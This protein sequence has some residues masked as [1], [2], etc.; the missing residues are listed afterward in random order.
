MTNAGPDPAEMVTLIDTPPLGVTLDEVTSSQGICSGIGPVTCDLGAIEAG[1]SRT[2]TL[3]VIPTVEG[4]LSNSAA[5]LSSTL[6]PNLLDNQALKAVNV[7][8]APG[9]SGGCTVNGT[10]GDDVLRG[11]S[12]RDVICGLGGS[13]TLYGLGGND[14]LKGS[15]G[16]DFLS[17]G[18]G[19]DRLL[20]GAGDDTMKGSGGRDTL[21]GGPGLDRFS[22]GGGRDRCANKDGEPAKGC[23]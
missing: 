9:G 7:L 16:N 4:L 5:V 21:K 6:D 18:A 19:K 15:L 8:A 12:G 17:G 3:G 2:V 10:D 13:D 23:D 11:T 1:G 20:A 14:V 22:G